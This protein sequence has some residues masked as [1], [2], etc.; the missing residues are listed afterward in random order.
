MIDESKLTTFDLERAKAGDEVAVLRWNGWFK[1]I[2]ATWVADSTGQFPVLVNCGDSIDW[3]CEQTDFLR[4]IP[5]TKTV[6]YGLFRRSGCLYTS[7]PFY[8]EAELRQK[9]KEQDCEILA[10]HSLE[11]PE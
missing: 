1:V 6:W 3:S 4:M 7:I 11:V 9:A 2:A 10:I 5:K 8:S